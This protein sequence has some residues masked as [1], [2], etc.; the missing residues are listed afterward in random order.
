MIKSV[1]IIVFIGF[2]EN[3]THLQ[4]VTNPYKRKLL[5]KLQK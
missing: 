5:S 4:L 1:K 2:N 3:E